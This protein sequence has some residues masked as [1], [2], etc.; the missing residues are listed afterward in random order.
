MN[1]PRRNWNTQTPGPDCDLRF[2]AF[3]YRHREEALLLLGRGQG[4]AIC[5]LS[6]GT[7]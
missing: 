1:W 7:V 5:V 2:M 3:L 6:R 4:D